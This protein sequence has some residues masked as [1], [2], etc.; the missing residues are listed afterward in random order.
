MCHGVLG[1]SP[2]QIMGMVENGKRPKIGDIPADVPKLLKTIMTKC[3][4]QDP[5]DRPT[6][7]G[8]IKNGTVHLPNYNSYTK[9]I[10]PLFIA[11]RTSLSALSET[12]ASEIKTSRRKL[13]SSI[14]GELDE[15]L[16]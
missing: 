2:G 13:L 10:I 16:I 14:H 7:H 9:Y 6:F 3:W 4:A 12:Y 5:T 15:V 11:I 8:K 1:L